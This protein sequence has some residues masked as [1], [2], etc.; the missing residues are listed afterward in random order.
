MKINRRLMAYVRQLEQ[1]KL[2]LEEGCQREAQAKARVLAEEAA[3]KAKDQFVSMVSH[4]ARS[5]M[6]HSPAALHA[7]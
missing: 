4:E 7:C 3:N 5:L 6:Q 1:M 2:A